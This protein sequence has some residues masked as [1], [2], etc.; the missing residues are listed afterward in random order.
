MLFII[1]TLIAVAL[2]GVGQAAPSPA[3]NLTVDPVINQVANLA[4]DDK[5]PNLTHIICQ[6]QMFVD[7]RT[8]FTEQ[9]IKYLRGKGSGAP[10]FGPGTNGKHC[11]RVSCE[12]AS[13]IY[14]CNDNGFGVAVPLATIADYAQAVHDDTDKRCNY[15][16]KNYRG[17]TDDKWVTWGQAFDANGW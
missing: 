7:A 8:D 2:L 13:G 9:N 1:S 5:N 10:Y 15:F 4:R 11:T 3:V 14:V 12:Y 17:G 16:V 6:P